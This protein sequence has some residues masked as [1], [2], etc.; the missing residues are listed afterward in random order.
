MPENIYRVM[1]EKIGY[2]KQEVLITVA[3]GETTTLNIELEKN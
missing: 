1:V 2:K 3:N